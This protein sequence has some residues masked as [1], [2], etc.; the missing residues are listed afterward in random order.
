MSNVT[1]SLRK[2]L[3]GIR[4]KKSLIDI[5]TEAGVDAKFPAQAVS[6]ALNRNDTISYTLADYV[7]SQTLLAGDPIER[8]MSTLEGSGLNKD[9]LE[10]VRNMIA[11]LRAHD[12]SATPPNV[13][14]VTA[15]HD[16][17]ELAI[18]PAI[19]DPRDVADKLREADA[20]Y[21]AKP[22]RKPTNRRDELPPYP[23][24]KGP[25]KGVIE[26][27]RFES[28]AAGFGEDLEKS[29]ALTY[30][31]ELPDWKDVHSLIVHGDSME[32]TLFDKD[33][34][35][36]KAFNG[37]KGLPL[38]SLERG[39][40]KTPVRDV[41]RHFQDDEIFVLAIG[42]E[43]PQVKRI[44]YDVENPLDWHLLIVSDNH[45]RYKT[46]VLRRETPVLFY[47]QVMG[48]GEGKYR[49]PKKDRGWN[50]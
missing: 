50:Q 12:R 21:P 48:I 16:R 29:E 7:L 34:I 27:P 10:L 32:E 25:G 8:A 19:P 45:R 41:K 42:N 17:N 2:L 15:D 4:R 23:L 46:R 35:L 20:P 36:V 39:D 26:I 11:H 30:V 13:A 33:L 18:K 38:E 49:A 6:D 28:V 37:G 24:A 5:A 3:E 1:G 43:K 9:E 44:S 31:R 22:E 14:E 40:M 47:G